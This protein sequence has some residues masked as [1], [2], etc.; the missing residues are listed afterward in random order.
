MAVKRS[1]E[2]TENENAVAAAGEEITK[3]NVTESESREEG[4]ESNMT[5]NEK[6][7][8]KEQIIKSERYRNYA[9]ILKGV[10]GERRYSLK[11]I[12]EA[13][14]EFLNREVM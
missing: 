14:K 12:D 5:V 11:E 13:I 7:Y 9:D 1:V 3:T 10:L 2:V 6:T 8:T 4:N